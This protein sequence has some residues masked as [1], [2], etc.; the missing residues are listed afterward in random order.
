MSIQGSSYN[1]P[2]R[3]PSGARARKIELATKN[4]LSCWVGEKEF[5][6]A[7]AWLTIFSAG[8]II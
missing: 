6:P 4:F 5:L 1:L 2:V 3:G 8:K 7:L